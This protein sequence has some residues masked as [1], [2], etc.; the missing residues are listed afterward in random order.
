VAAGCAASYTQIVEASMSGSGGYNS[1]QATLD[2]R[3]SNGLSLLLNYTWSRALDDLPY[4]LGVSNTEDLNAGE[5]Y[6]YP[7]YP[8]GVSGGTPAK[9]K[10]LDY[11]PSDFDHPSAISASYVYQ[12]PKLGEGPGAL[13][14]VVNGW[15]MSGLIQHHSGDALTVTAGSDVSLTGLNQDRGQRNATL[16]VYSSQSGAGTCTTSAHCRNWLASGAFAK[17]VNT[18]AL[19]GTGFGNVQKGS[20]RGPGY[21]NW[22]A[23]MI[24][25]FPIYRESDMV[26]RAEYF[27]VLNHTIPGDPATSLSSATYGQVTSENAAGPRIAQFSL[28][29]RF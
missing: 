4:A 5:S 26:F 24:R 23:A 17:P 12:F 3:M 9:Y 25:T 6:V 8:A 11:G 10:S 14:A 15:R 28:K 22:D 13:R 20:I 1:L 7:V 2:K 27:D 21:T 19:S 18:G 16:P 29:Y